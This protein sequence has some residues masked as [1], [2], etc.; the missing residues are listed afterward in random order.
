MKTHRIIGAFVVGGL[1]FISPSFAVTRYV[2]V[3][4]ATPVAPY[5]NWATASTNIQMA[6]VWSDSGDEI[7]VAPG[8]Y[9]QYGSHLELPYGKALTLR[10]TQ[11][12]AAVIDAQRLSMAMWIDGSNSLVEGFT[13]RNG[14]DDGGPGG[15]YISTAC[16]MRDCLVT[17]NQAWGP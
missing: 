8:V 1:L 3:S 12:R 11:S 4:N 9:R 15:V 17:S 7:L 6:I 13:V 16:T 10:S 14:L 2:N 5:T